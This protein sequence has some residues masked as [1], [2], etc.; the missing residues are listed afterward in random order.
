[1]HVKKVLIY[2]YKASQKYSSRDAIPLSK[3]S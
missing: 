2:Y 1:V 3:S